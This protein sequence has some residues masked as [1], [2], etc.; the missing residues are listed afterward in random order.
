M[1]CWAC[2]WIIID[3]VFE[4]QQPKPGSV[5]FCTDRPYNAAKQSVF[6]ACTTEFCWSDRNKKRFVECI[7]VA[8]FAIFFR[9]GAPLA[10]LLLF[11][12][13]DSILAYKKPYNITRFRFVSWHIQAV[14]LKLDTAKKVYSMNK[15]LFLGVFSSP[16]FAMRGQAPRCDLS[17]FDKL[18]LRRLR[19]SRILGISWLLRLTTVH[20]Y[21]HSLLPWALLV[22]YL[23]K[24]CGFKLIVP[25]SRMSARLHCQLAVVTKAIIN[26]LLVSRPQVQ[27]KLMRAEG[28]Y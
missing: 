10:S 4:Q 24:C 5:S 15:G 28:D 11:T 16:W 20:S 13:A 21:Y 26:I 22:L 17:C 9:T 8:V 25:G 7:H 2:L 23:M 12:L 14:C 3:F 6:G 1:D 27:H 19:Y 18:C